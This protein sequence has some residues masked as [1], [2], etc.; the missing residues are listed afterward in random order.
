MHSAV[1]GLSW[2]TASQEVRDRAY[3]APEVEQE[4]VE[5]LKQSAGV[6]QVAILSTCNRVELYIVDPS[7]EETIERVWQIWFEFCRMPRTDME[8][9]Y[10]HF[11]EDAVRHLFQVSASVDS[12]IQGETQISGQI[13]DARARAQ[14]RG[15]DFFLLRL[16]QDALAS[17]KR[18]RTA[19][20]LGEGSVSIA[21]TAVQFAYDWL[22]L[23]K[24]KVA[25]IGAGAMAEAAWRSFRHHGVKRFVYVNRTPEKLKPWLLEAPGELCGLDGLERA[26]E[27][28]VVLAAVRCHGH[29]IHPDSLVRGDQLLLDISAPRV[30]DPAC[31][32]HPG[33]RLVAIDDLQSV[34]A[35]NRQ[36]RADQAEQATQLIEDDVQRFCHWLRS[37]SILDDIRQVREAAHEIATEL[38]HRHARHLERLAG[39]EQFDLELE[40]FARLLANQ[41]LHQPVHTAKDFAARGDEMHARRVLQI[42]S[43]PSP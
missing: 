10:R 37:R 16:F 30:I 18:I 11:H 3:I 23:P 36:Q 20:T 39:S 14:E 43:R 7:P 2:K 13:R 12:L 6:E 21:S 29:L 24:A 40:G 25:I 33:T 38:A 28:D 42:F 19:T 34:V 8:C 41:L 35:Q 22:D 5:R 9:L 32:C 15:A 26:M 17:S 27:C 1:V 31:T 4:L